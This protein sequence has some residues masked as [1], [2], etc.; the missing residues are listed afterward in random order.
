MTS[1]TTQQTKLDLE[2]VP[3]E[4]RLDIRKCNGIIPLYMHQFWNSIYKHHNFYRLKIDKKKRFKL[5]LEVFRDI[6]KIFPKIKDQDF[7]ALPSEED[8]LSFLRELGHTRVVNSLNDE[9]KAYKTYLAY[10]TSTVPPKVFMKF[11]KA[12]PSKKDSVPVPTDEEPGQKGKRV[13]RSTKKSSTTLTTGIIIREPPVETYLKRKEK[14]DVARGKGIDLLSEVAL[15]KE[16]QMKEVRK[17]RLRDF[18]KSH[19]SGSSSVAEKPP[20]VENI[21]PPITNERTGDKPR[22]PDVTKDDSTENSESDQQDDDDDDDDDEVKDDD[23]DDDED[24]D[25]YSSRSSDIAS[26]FLNFSDIP[27][28]D[29][30]IVSSLDVHVHHENK[31]KTPQTGPTQNWLMTLVASTSTGKSMKE[32]DELISTP[33]DFSSYVLN[34]L[35]IKNLTQ[36]NLLGPAFRHLKGTHL[37]YAELEYD[38]EECYK[39]SSSVRVEFFINNDLKYLQRE[40]FTMTYT[41]STTKKKSTQ[42]DLPGIEDMVPNIWSPVKVSYDKHALWVTHVSVMRK[43]GYRYLEEIVVR[44]ADNEL[45]K[46]KE[47]DD[48]ANFEIALRMFIRSLVIQKFTKN[49]DMEYLIKRRWS[50]LEKKRSHYMIKDINKLLKERRMMRSLE[51]FVG[52]RLYETD[53]RLL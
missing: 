2:L 16:A 37:I 25:D 36:E 52:G 53:L 23:K 42:Y 15:T 32:F 5:T 4:N 17:K 12:S 47:G 20:S 26:K 3:K 31:D 29:T 38:F 28:A 27:P 33:I 9:S 41:T 45:H 13:K 24:D 19:P 43:H 39:K 11:K 34:G 48:V 30:K 49:I 6:F 10:A 1:I 50:T 14:V 40:I 35:K 18:H 21:T 51:K 8:T 22:V 7:D 46:F 44:R